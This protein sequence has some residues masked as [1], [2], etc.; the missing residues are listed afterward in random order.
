M[1]ERETLTWDDFGRAGRELLSPLPHTADL[2][3]ATVLIVDDVAD[4]G[5]RFLR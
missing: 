5:P 2:E 3:G 4:T 1:A